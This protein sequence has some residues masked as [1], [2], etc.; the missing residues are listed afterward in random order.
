MA[1][2]HPKDV[3]NGTGSL[4]VS[5]ALFDIPKLFA[6]FLIGSSWTVASAAC[7]NP[8][9]AVP[10][11]NATSPIPAGGHTA[12]KPAPKAIAAPPKQKSQ[13]SFV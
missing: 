7:P 2:I 9:K 5:Y 6:K 10:V 11:P 4:A 13:C 1:P 3:K 8:I 12:V